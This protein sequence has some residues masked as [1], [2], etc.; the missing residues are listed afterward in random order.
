MNIEQMIGYNDEYHPIGKVRKMLEKGEVPDL[1]FTGPP[2][3]GK[4]ELALALARALNAEIHELNASDDRGIDM[5]RTRLKLLTTTR[6][7]TQRVI[8]LDEADGLTKQAQEALRRMM[9]TGNALF[10]LTANDESGIIPALKSRC[11]HLGFPAY[12]DA[13][14]GQ[15]I[16]RFRDDATA[17]QRKA[18]FAIAQGDMRVLTRLINYSDPTDWGSLVR[19]DVSSNA[20]LSLAGGLWEDL[21]SELTH[22]TARGGN[23]VYVLSQLHSKVRD[24]VGDLMTVEQFHTY[25]RVW[26]DAVLAAHQWPLGDEEF[27]DWVVGTMA[28]LHRGVNE[29]NKEKGD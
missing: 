15:L 6:S 24:M 12:T 14:M 10:I 21:R 7:L 1:L 27:I 11:H 22:L 5:V 17:E 4:T 19:D 25:S 9:E 28:S 29:Q 3:R 2:G 18:A 16:T 13:Q 23:R 26:G 8:L 20:A